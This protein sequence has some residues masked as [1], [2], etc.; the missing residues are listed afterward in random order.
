MH[1]N[2]R[3]GVVNQSQGWGREDW[4]QISQWDLHV[5]KMVTSIGQEKGEANKT[6]KLF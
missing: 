5:L 4:A 2:Q 6:T 1:R 3:T